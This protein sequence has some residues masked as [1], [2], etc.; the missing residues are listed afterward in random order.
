VRKILSSSNFVK[1]LG[2][3]VLQTHIGFIRQDRND[4]DYKGLIKAMQRIAD[5]CKRNGQSFALETEQE[6]LMF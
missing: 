6:K 4:L 3:N 1:K 5:Y 2:V